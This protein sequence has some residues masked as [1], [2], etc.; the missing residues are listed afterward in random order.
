M[1]KKRLF[2]EF[3]PVSSEAW[4][5]K[6]TADLKGADYDKKLVWKTEEGFDVHPYYRNEDLEKLNAG[7]ISR[8]W[9]IRQDFAAGPSP[10]AVNGKIRNA[11]NRGAQ[12]VGI[13][14]SELNGRSEK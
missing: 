3:P 2:E 9:K 14:M 13:D 10:E 5:A 1:T 6:V 11:I 7:K 4:K 8:D 12:S